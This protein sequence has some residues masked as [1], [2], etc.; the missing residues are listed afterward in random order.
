VVVSRSNRLSQPE[1]GCQ[2]GQLRV[3]GR[4]VIW[5]GRASTDPGPFV[6]SPVDV[7]GLA[8]YLSVAALILPG[9]HCER[10]GRRRL[11]GTTRRR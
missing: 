8:I 7:T 3:S 2:S 4:A 5:P 6:A 1:H 11:C 9:T 10:A